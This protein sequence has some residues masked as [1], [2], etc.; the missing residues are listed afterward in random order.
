MS[1]TDIPVRTCKK[2]G[3]T[4]PLTS[5]FFYPN[6]RY[7]KIGFFYQCIE[8][9]VK[10]RKEWRETNKIV[11]T[12]T[13]KSVESKKCHACGKMKPS[14]EFSVSRGNKNGLND[15]CKECLNPYRRLYPYNITKKEYDKMLE[16]QDNKCIICGVEF[17]SQVKKTTPCIHHDHH[18]G[19]VKGI[20]CNNCNLGFGM[21]KDD[22]EL[23][24]K[25]LNF[26][27]G[28]YY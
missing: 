4:L 25:A 18:T 16:V 8:C 19:E 10:A 9:M 2:C 20:L 13:T 17:N 24:Q 28:E 23:M 3:R 26:F 12:Y 1:A 11:N 15:K 6:K 27:R 22:V 21:F 14:S 5:S 7:K